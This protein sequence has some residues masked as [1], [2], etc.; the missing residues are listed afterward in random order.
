[1]G[2][3]AAQGGDPAESLPKLTNVPTKEPTFGTCQP[4]A[5]AT[6]DFSTFPLIPLPQPLTEEPQQKRKV[7]KQD[8]T[9]LS[10]QQDLK[11][12]E[13]PMGGREE[14]SIGFTID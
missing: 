5:P 1:M 4:R 9:L 14:Y 12:G 3:T 11:P 8:H 10:P 13:S 6:W 2:G 7:R